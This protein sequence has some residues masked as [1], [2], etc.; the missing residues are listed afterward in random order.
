[1]VIIQKERIKITKTWR[2]LKIKSFNI[3]K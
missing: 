3:A 2:K 1:L